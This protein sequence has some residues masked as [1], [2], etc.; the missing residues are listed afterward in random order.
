MTIEEIRKRDYTQK[1]REEG[2]EKGI[3]KGIVEGKRQE[4]E[5]VAKKLLKNGIPIEIIIESTD[6]TLEEIEKLGKQLDS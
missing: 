1:G 6:L 3:E 5:Q 4:K 2:I